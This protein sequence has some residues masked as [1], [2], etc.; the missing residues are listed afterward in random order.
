MGEI[1][2]ESDRIDRI[3]LITRGCDWVVCMQRIVKVK[4]A[5]MIKDVKMVKYVVYWWEEE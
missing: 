2:A 1:E 5:L 3:Y 4:A